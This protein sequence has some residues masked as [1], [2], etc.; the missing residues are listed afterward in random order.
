MNWEAVSAIA[1]ILGLAI[2]IA[3]LMYLAFQVR[4]SN[5]IAQA[6]SL[7]SI[8]DGQRDRSIIPWIVDPEI[9]DVFAAGLNSFESLNASD[10]RRCFLTITE[11][12]LQMQNVIQL[13]EK[14]L[15]ADV[16]YE[17]WLAF[18]T[19]VVITPG[20]KKIWELMKIQL[21]PTVAKAMDDYI[22]ANPDAP[23]F[24]DINPLFRV[25]KESDTP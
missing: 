22:S 3:T 12:V 6:N 9:G 2:L 24:S 13:Y 5:R 14:G 16:E 18:T 4:D 1:E 20:G 21:T 10:K 11:M 7:Q 17:A 15:I 19:S 8:L 23:S 25:E